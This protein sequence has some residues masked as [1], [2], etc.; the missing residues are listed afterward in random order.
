MSSRSTDQI[1]AVGH[2]DAG[3]F[4]LRRTADTDT[5]ELPHVAA[6]VVSAGRRE[7]LEKNNQQ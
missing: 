2:Q 7:K 6:P 1:R 4:E 5:V 3:V